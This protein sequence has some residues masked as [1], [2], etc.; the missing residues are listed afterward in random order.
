MNEFPF[1]RVHLDILN[2]E[3]RLFFERSSYLNG[4][5]WMEGSW[6]TLTLQNP[7]DLPCSFGS[8]VEI[9]RRVLEFSALLWSWEI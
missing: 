7:M 6:K 9:W 3:Q 2:L 5:L 1:M 8:R 4:F